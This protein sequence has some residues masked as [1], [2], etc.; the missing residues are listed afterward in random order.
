MIDKP[1]DVGAIDLPS[2]ENP[3]DPEAGSEE[4]G[5]EK[6]S[7]EGEGKGEGGQAP[8]PVKIGEKEYTPEQLADLVKKGQDYDSLL[9][10]YTR[11][12][13]R[14]A[15]IDKGQKGEPEP[16]EEKP[17]YHDPNWVPKSYKELAEA[18]K[19]AE[20]RGEQKAIAHLQK[21]DANKA[22]A[23]KLVDDFVEGVK[24]KDSEFD[25]K[26]FYDFVAKHK[27]P[28][29]SIN[30]LQAAYSVY[31]EVRTTEAKIPKGEKGRKDFVSKPGGGKGT[32]Y[33]A[34]D[35]EIRGS[36]SVFDAAMDAFHR[37]KK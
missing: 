7:E 13:Q 4:G 21:M 8:Q 6:P 28:A 19:M 22:E 5:E 26:D 15:D 32:P 36:G 31:A 34:S 35:K 25:D 27:L 18:I 14:L 30:D 16:A 1:S 37:L 33:S 11:K 29:N 12:S 24:A 17:P 23:V 10:D 3:L 20:E 2:E 9:P